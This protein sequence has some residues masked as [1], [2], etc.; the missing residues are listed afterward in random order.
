MKFEYLRH[1]VMKNKH[2]IQ[3]PFD[4]IFNEIGLEGIIKICEYMG[5]STVYI[6]TI[7]RIF[8]DCL[9][10]ELKNGHNGNYTELSECFGVTERHVRRLL[11]ER[12]NIE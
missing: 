4:E 5:G 2:L 12:R 1:A 10:E 11:N 7:R 3:P 8:Y 6:P 9:L